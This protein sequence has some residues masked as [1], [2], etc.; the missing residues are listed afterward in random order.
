MFNKYLS[1]PRVEF[2][3]MPRHA[4]YS[5]ALIKQARAERVL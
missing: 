1:N 2:N 4:L 5:L 3:A